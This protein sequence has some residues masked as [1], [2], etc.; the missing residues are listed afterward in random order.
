M[1]TQTTIPH[2]VG[3]SVTRV[4][5]REKV[6]GAALFADDIQFGPGLLFARIKRSPYPHAMIKRVDISKA[7]A[8]P[9]VKA[10]VTGD[11]FP[12]FTGFYLQ[13]RHI[14]CR[15]RARYVGDPI[16]G[17]AAISETIA[18]QALNLIEVDF[19]PLPGVFDAEF[20]ATAD[21]PLLHPDLGK[22]KVVNFVFPEAGTN[23]SN[24]FKIRKGDTD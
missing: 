18:E 6:T 2:P 13:A 22:Y 14:F 21:A 23:I 11:D 16:V 10:V 20:G 8:L 4:D 15:D 19:E 3:D 17:V 5:A 7:L 9:G 1:T 12:G 24:H